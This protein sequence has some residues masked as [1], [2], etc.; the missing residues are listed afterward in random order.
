MIRLLVYAAL[1]AAFA[2]ATH[3][4]ARVHERDAGEEVVSVAGEWK[5]SGKPV[6]VQEL[7]SGPLESVTKISGVM[8]AGGELLAETTPEI[9]R[10]VRAE[11][12]FDGCGVRPLSGVVERVS[13]TP[14]LA[15]GLHKAVLKVRSGAP[16][17]GSIIVACVRSAASGRVLRVPRAAVITGANGRFVWVV[18]DGK[19]ARKTPEVGESDDRFFRVRSGLAKGDRV[20]VEGWRELADGDRVRVRN[21]ADGKGPS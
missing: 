15:T 17:A 2:A 6:A 1:I 16:P 13:E 7:G 19:A 9:A 10:A 12:H 8:R 21:A 11:Q 4:R 18:R 3:F 5:K 20:V 14:D